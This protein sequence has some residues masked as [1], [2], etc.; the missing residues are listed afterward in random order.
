MQSLWTAHQNLQIQQRPQCGRFDL[1]QNHA[2]LC[3]LFAIIFHRGIDGIFG[4]HRAVDFYRRQGQFF[5]QLGV[6]D[7]FRFVQRLAL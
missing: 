4:Q 6:L 7:R 2:D 5:G 1:Y 3:V